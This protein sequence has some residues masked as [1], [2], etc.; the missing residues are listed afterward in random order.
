MPM[1]RT[2]GWIGLAA[3]MIWTALTP[4][5]VAEPGD[6]YTGTASQQTSCCASHGRSFS[7]PL[8]KLG[9][10]LANLTFGWLEVPQNLDNGYAQRPDDVATGLFTG[11]AAGLVKTVQRTGVG[12]Y[13]TLTF[14]LPL[15]AEY[16]P[17]LPPLKYFKQHYSIERVY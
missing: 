4:M 13:E 10:G 7:R 16:E 17:I 11:V 1:T 3:A 5:S 2:M 9:R 6:A 12:A 15:P 14:W 8:T